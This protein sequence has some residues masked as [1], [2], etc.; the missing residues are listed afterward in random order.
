MKRTEH[1]FLAMGLMFLAAW[2]GLRLYSFAGSTIG[3]RNFERNGRGRVSDRE[4]LFQSS[5]FRLG[6]AD[7]VFTHQKS[8]IQ[9]ANAPLA[10]LRIPAINLIVPI[11]NGTDDSALNRGV[12]RIPGSAE[13]GRTGNLGI[14]GHR[15]G[16]FRRLGELSTGDLIEVDRAGHADRYV[17]AGSRIV[18]P[19][20]IS[21]L[22][23]TQS[24]T[25]TL[26]TCFP[27]YFAGPAPE[28]YV[29]IAAFKSSSESEVAENYG[30][31]SNQRRSDEEDK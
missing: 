13:P 27:F 15:D 22:Q 26:V 31:F 16:F 18:K 14:A 11:F 17:V 24:P 6:S 25:L 30:D 21:V 4:R 20:D 23:R 29:V 5:D 8:L 7:H 1:V 28:R 12:G 19:D 2:G 9:P 3:I 10:I